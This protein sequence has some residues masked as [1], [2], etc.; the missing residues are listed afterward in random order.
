MRALFHPMTRDARGRLGVGVDLDYG[1]GRDPMSIH[2]DVPREFESHAKAW[3]KQWIGMA[4]NYV[5]MLPSQ[6]FAGIPL[7]PAFGAAMAAAP[8]PSRR[9]RAR[10]AGAQA[11]RAYRRASSAR[12]QA[13]LLNIAEGIQRGDARAAEAADKLEDAARASQIAQA[14]A[15][16]DPRAKAHRARLEQDPSDE[17]AEA[18]GMIDSC[19][20]A[21]KA[22]CECGPR[23]IQ[24][25]VDELLAS[26]WDEDPEYLL[27]EMYDEADMALSIVKNAGTEMADSIFTEY[28][29]DYDSLKA[30]VLAESW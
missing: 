16:G 21:Q 8:R 15:A 30:R 17:A 11:A 27:T 29:G 23:T 22:P 20:K 12:G 10:A 2:I 13:L 4:K 5:G 18:A 9:S 1:P 7:T 26:Q 6:S 25:S 24:E 14:I 3:L 19:L 28:R